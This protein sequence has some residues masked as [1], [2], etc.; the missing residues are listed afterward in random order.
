MPTKIK[1]NTFSDERGHLTVVDNMLPFDIK[2]VFYIYGVTN[3]VRGG[4]AH[5]KTMQALICINGSCVIESTDGKKSETIKLD[6]PTECLI[7]QPQD[8]RTMHSFT[9][10]AILMVLA[11]ENYDKMD[12]IFEK[13]I[14]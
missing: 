1:L 8:W 9:T 12:Y 4:H 2:R 11:S 3:K 10:D 6:K 7:L 13:P 5:K 14:K